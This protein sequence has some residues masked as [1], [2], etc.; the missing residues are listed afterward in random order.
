M[1]DLQALG[2]KADEVLGL[3]APPEPLEPLAEHVEPGER[4]EC[5]VCGYRSVP[6]WLN[7]KAGALGSSDLVAGQ[8]DLGA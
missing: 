7:N 4:M 5:Q 3:E 6:Q 1:R 8:L 2:R